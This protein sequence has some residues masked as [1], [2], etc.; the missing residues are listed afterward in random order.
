[1]TPIKVSTAVALSLLLPAKAAFA[2][3]SQYSNSPYG[4]GQYG[5][6]Q[7][8][9]YGTQGGSG[10]QGGYNPGAPPSQYGS[11]SERYDRDQ[12]AS[13]KDD[14][15]RGLEFFYANAGVGLSVLG[16]QTFS[17]SKL[18]IEKTSGVGPAVDVGLGLR[19]LI[20]TFGPRF[21]YH[22][23]SSFNLWQL[24]GEVGL[25]IPAGK[26]DP[27]VTLSGGYA[28]VGSLDQDV[29][30]GSSSSVSSSDVS[31]TGGSVGLAGGLDYY[32]TKAFSVGGEVGAQFLFLSRGAVS[33]APAELANSSAGV[34][35]N[36]LV[37]AHVGLHL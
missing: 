18:A 9:P 20:F 15:K 25:H 2:Q 33:G 30:P 31:V 19:L 37:Q 14:S 10:T 29:I 32:A 12:S 3:Q 35:G 36:L 34:G 8:A 21:R 1:M 22:Q 23:L 11:A 27:Y 28:A 17:G 24:T 4:N 13:S 5:N 7:Q 6:Q 16:M 26:L